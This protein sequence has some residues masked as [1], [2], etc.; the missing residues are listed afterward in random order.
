MSDI[1]GEDKDPKR[2][3]DREEL[4]FLMGVCAM[5]TK[6]SKQMLKLLPNLDPEELSILSDTTPLNNL[7]DRLEQEQDEDDEVRRKMR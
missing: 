3:K 4:A 5:L 2:P 7:C 1:P 6:R